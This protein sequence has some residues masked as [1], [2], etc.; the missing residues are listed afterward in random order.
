TDSPSCAAN[1]VP[2]EQLSTDLASAT[3]TPS[4]AMIVPNLCE[5]GHD[6]PCVDGRPGGLVSADGFLRTW[7]PR[8]LKS[9]AY[10]SGG[11]LIVTFDEAESDDAS[12]CCDEPVGPKPPNNGADTPGNG[13]GGRSREAR[14]KRCL[15]CDVAAAS[16]GSNSFSPEASVSPRS[17]SVSS[18]ESTTAVSEVTSDLAISERWRARSSTLQPSASESSKRVG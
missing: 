9:P 7:V 2:L 10:K 3:T 8:I 5:D 15:A 6:S 4:Y 13:G 11:L 14:R 17:I 18:S 1:D 16:S 12:S